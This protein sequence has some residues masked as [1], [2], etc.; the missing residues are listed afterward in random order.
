[1][2]KSGPRFASPILFIAKASGVLK[3]TQ[4]HSGIACHFRFASRVVFLLALATGSAQAQLV[5]EKTVHNLRAQPGDEKVEAVFPFRNA[6]AFPVKITQIQSS[7]GCTTA[8]SEKELYA[9][10]E[11]GEITGIF[12][13]GGRVGRQNKT[14]TVRTDPPS[15][16][17]ICLAMVTE[18]SENVALDRRVVFW[19][20]GE[21]PEARE[22]HLKVLQTVP[23]RIVR[24]DS[25][26]PRLRATL[27]EIAPGREY[28][29]QVRVADTS[30]PL[31]G[32][33]VL[34][35]DSPAGSPQTF[36]VRARVK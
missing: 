7:C 18:I 3:S 20:R 11:S 34:V 19:S 10:G 14:I 21:P 29:L 16:K 32:E 13:I 9:P 27:R 31:K 12:K 4:N 35:G 24:A 15:A 17:P 8:R 22:I 28:L 30:A 5:W 6:G 33:V 25:S 36:T 2:K 1:M 26:D 23:I